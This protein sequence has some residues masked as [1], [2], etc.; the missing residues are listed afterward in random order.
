MVFGLAP[1]GSLYANQRL[2]TKSCTSF[3]ITSAHLI[4][5]TAQHLLKLVHLTSVDGNEIL[6]LPQRTRAEAV[7]EL[8]VPP[9]EPENDERCRTIERGARIVSVVPTI[10]AVIL[11][12]PRGNLETVYPRAMVVGRIRECITAKDYK[13]AFYACR[14]QRVDQNILHDFAPHQFISNVGLFIDQVE[15]VEYIDLFLSQL[16]Y[17]AWSA[18]LGCPDIF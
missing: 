15:K 7:T 8:V 9:D 16:R 2:L 14:N 5:T 1:S 3:V 12:M 6:H 11:Q 18:C 13:S 10:F 17:V 4:F